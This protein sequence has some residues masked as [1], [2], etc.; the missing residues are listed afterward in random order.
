MIYS[1]AITEVLNVA[2]WQS[3]VVARAEPCSHEAMLSLS[4]F[5]EA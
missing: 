2:M 3:G 5:G 4:H 1:C